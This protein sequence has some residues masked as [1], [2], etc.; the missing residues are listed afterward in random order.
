MI[1]EENKIKFNFKI[2]NINNE[3][4]NVK[5]A[6]FSNLKI[7]TLDPG[8]FT[9][10]NNLEHIDMS[11]NAITELNESIFNGL[12]LKTINFS[13]NSITKLK[14]TIFSCLSST[15]EEINFKMNKL[16][17]LESKMFSDLDN[18]KRADFSLNFL[19]FDKKVLFREIFKYELIVENGQF[20]KGKVLLESVL[21][22]SNLICFINN[23]EIDFDK[24]RIYSM[25]KTPLDILIQNE[26]FETSFVKDVIENLQVF[27]RNR[28]IRKENNF[29]ID[30]KSDQTFK[31]VLVRED[32]YLLQHFLSYNLN[33][34]LTID[35]KDYT[36]ILFGMLYLII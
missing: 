22:C 18:L 1:E 28:Q 10:L 13:Y 12:K 25:D 31:C 23:G 34:N 24:F 35:F 26:K 17:I 30:F 11:N 19:A 4:E 14:P 6:K 9:N 3:S 5:S 20:K 33:F 32:E 8:I 7:I 2:S 36:K 21:D 27:L 15:L 16:K 29:S